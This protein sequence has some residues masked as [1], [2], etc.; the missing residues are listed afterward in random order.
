VKK[1]AVTPRTLSP[2]GSARRRPFTKIT[3][4]KCQ[5]SMRLEHGEVDIQDVELP[6][7]ELKK[8]LFCQ[9]IHVHC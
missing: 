1:V 5:Y 3:M 2:R 4:P 8:V 6:G 7:L 9:T